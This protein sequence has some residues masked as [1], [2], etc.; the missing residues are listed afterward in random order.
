MKIEN[1]FNNF[2]NRFY[3]IVDKIGIHNFVLVMFIFVVFL[4]TGLYSTFSISTSNDGED[5]INGLDT[6]RFILGLD[7]SNTVTVAARSVKN[8]DLTVT[9]FSDVESLYGIYYSSSSDL[10]DVVIGSV[11]D[12][13]YPSVGMIDTNSSNIVTIKVI[14]NSSSDVTLEFGMTSGVSNGGDFVLPSDSYLVNSLP[15]YIKEFNNINEESYFHNN[16][17]R[18]NIKNVYFVD[19]IDLDEAVESWD[20][21]VYDVAKIMSWVEK[22]EVDGYY[23][24]YIGSYDVIKA[25]SLAYYFSDMTSV[26]SIKL[27]N[28]D[29]SITNDMT[30]MF[31][32][33]GYDSSIFSLDLGNNFDTSNVYN[34]SQMFE[35]TGYNN[36]EFVLDLKDKFDTSNVVDMS[37]MFNSTGYNSMIFSL[38]LG[39]KFNTS[40]VIDMS[41]MFYDM[42]YLN[43]NLMLDITMFNFDKVT[44]YD[45]MFNYK[46]SQSLYVNNVDAQ[47][48]ILDKEFINLSSDNVLIK[49]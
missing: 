22:N 49:N 9:S 25:T 34:M 16:R 15:N 41:Y 7:D 19:Y 44:I 38:D 8:I 46:I 23:D 31:Y 13:E 37:R 3:G 24:L 26:D 20:M 32:N 5:I 6:K 29:T 48:W 11:V 18:K 14:N 45:D 30:A 36:T 43:N 28:L 12:S 42:G 10:S 47:K 2:L 40:N 1:S 35:Y 39:E 4:V 17:Y 21:S 33:T 27:D